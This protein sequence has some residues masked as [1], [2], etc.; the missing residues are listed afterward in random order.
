MVRLAIVGNGDRAARHVAAARQT[1]G[2]DVVGVTEGDSRTAIEDLLRGAEVDAIDVCIPLGQADELSRAAAR[3]GKRVV[4]E[5]LPGKSAAEA[6]RLIADCQAAGRTLNLL[7]PGRWQP[8]VKDLK[9]TLDAGKLGPLRYAHAA[10]VW[11]GSED[12]QEARRAW[13]VPPGAE[14]AGQFLV[15]HATGTLDLL[16]WFFDDAPVARVFARGCPLDGPEADSWYVSIVLFFADASQ[17]ICEVGLTSSFAE[18]TGLQRLALTGLRGSAYYNERDA[19]VIVGASGLR[20]LVDDPVDGLT[21]AFADWVAGANGVTA[22]AIEDGRDTLRVA[23]A[24]AES[25][26]TGQPVEVGN[27]DGD[28]DHR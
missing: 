14:D 22:D 9:A 26:R 3:A 5:Y 1:E 13:G 17:A 2:I 10:S 25:L 11:H 4:V 20:P 8:L 12:E 19:D 27:E 7:R 24:A 23:L 18:N 16:R 15:E 21:A 28:H 6:D